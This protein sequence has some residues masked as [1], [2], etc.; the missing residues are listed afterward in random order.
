[1]TMTK[2]L[3]LAVTLVALAGC[4]TNGGTSGVAQIGRDSYT[5]RALSER[6]VSEAKQKALTTADAYCREQKRN[7]M[8][9]KDFG[10]TEADTNEKYY[11]LTFMCLGTGDEDFQR[12]KRVDVKAGQE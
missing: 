11:D 3:M 10:G 1:M 4:V 2:T 8:L 12:I 6:S 5:I 7:V 9:V